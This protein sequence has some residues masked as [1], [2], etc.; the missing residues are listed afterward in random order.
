MKESHFSIEQSQWYPWVYD[1]YVF[2]Q[3]NHTAE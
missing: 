1:G 2:K 3:Q